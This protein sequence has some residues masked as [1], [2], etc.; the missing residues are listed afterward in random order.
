MRLTP[1]MNFAV[2]AATA[3]LAVILGL[4][5]VRVLGWLLRCCPGRCGFSVG[6]SSFFF[7]IRLYRYRWRFFRAPI[8]AK[9][10]WNNCSK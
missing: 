7:D 5:M 4:P 6:P 10:G 8:T 9:P 2:V 1:S 3:S